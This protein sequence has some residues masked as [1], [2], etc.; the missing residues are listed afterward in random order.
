MG[1]SA[2]GACHDG[3]RDGLGNLWISKRGISF[4]HTPRASNNGGPLKMSMRNG[5]SCDTR[6]LRNGQGNA[7][8]ADDGQHRQRMPE[9]HPPALGGQARVKA[10][11]RFGQRARQMIGSFFE[12]AFGAAA[13]LRL[14]AVQ[15]QR[16]APRTANAVE[17]GPIPAQYSQQVPGP[18]EGARTYGREADFGG[19]TLHGGHLHRQHQA[20]DASFCMGEDR[21]RCDGSG[22]GIGR[23][24]RQTLAECDGA[25]RACS[26]LALRVDCFDARKEFRQV[27]SSRLQRGLQAVARRERA[28]QHKGAGIGDIELEGV[29]QDQRRRRAL[30]M[31]DGLEAQ[32]PLHSVAGHEIHLSTAPREGLDQAKDVVVGDRMHG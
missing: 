13:F 10:R 31:L 16:A 1:V 17:P 15:R 28:R 30:A 21:P 29:L 25:V 20:V 6:Q 19:V 2:G 9:C 3:A 27:S 7:D 22:R 26:K 32:A 18:L 8:Q 5:E 4:M 14:L 24:R 12:L 11:R 23:E